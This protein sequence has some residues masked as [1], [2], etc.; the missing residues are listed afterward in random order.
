MKRLIPAA[1]AAFTLAILAIPPVASAATT[2]PT[3]YNKLWSGYV[4]TGGSYAEAYTEFH[5]PTAD[6]KHT[7]MQGGNGTMIW[8]GLD[9]WTSPSVEQA[10]VLLQCVPGKHGP[11]ASYRAF[12]EMFQPGG[13]KGTRPSYVHSVKPGEVIDVEVWHERDNA[14]QYVLL[15]ADTPARGG[16]DNWFVQHHTQCSTCQ[17]QARSRSSSARC[18]PRT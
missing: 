17:N 4:V 13:G 18:E 3:S 9:G 10:G 1:I 7:R 16:F 5:M 15:L 11:T 8:A 14:S 12:T 2:L 6:C